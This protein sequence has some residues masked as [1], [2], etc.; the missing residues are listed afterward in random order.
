MIQKTD[1]GK[2][3]LDAIF[4]DV[5][6][7]G[8]NLN[9][10]SVASRLNSLANYV[11]KAKQGVSLAGKLNKKECKAS[12]QAL[13]SRFH[14]FTLR[15]THARRTLRHAEKI[16]KRRAVVIA[17]ANEELGNY[18]KFAAFNR[19]NRRHWKKFWG[20]TTKG[21]KIVSGLIARVRTHVAQLHRQNKRAALIELPASYNTALS[22]ITSEFESNMDNLGGLRP[23][24]ASLLE[25]A[26]KTKTLRKK[27]T[28]RAF[29]QLLGRLAEKFHDDINTFEEENEHQTGLF[30]GLSSLFDDSVNRS[31]RVVAG[32]NA[33]QKASAGK[34]DWFKYGV[35]G[36]QFLADASTNIVDLKAKECRNVSDVVH[37]TSLKYRRFL[38][39]VGQVQ[40]VL[41]DRFHT[42]RSFIEQASNTEP[43]SN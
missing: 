24:I 17:R 20:A 32:L 2:E 3:V 11:K 43:E 29:R 18:S 30:D 40:E 38:N 4:L 25:L 26:M 8:P 9:A 36:A 39:V 5:A 42:L 35:R 14:D 23:I 31:Q 1:E 7:V 15:L 34:I 28:R 19:S 41:S 27:G 37:S 12:L 13:R 33:L 16:S 6:L 10:A 21:A 22:E